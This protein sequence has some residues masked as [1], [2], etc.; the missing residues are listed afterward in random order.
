MGFARASMMRGAI[1]VTLM[2]SLAGGRGEAQ[3]PHWVVAWAASAQGP[4]PIGNPTAQPDLRFAFP[5]DTLGARDQTFRLIV[6]P[7]V[8]G[9]AARIRLSNAFGARPVDFDGIYVGLQTSGAATLAGH[10][11]PVTFRG[12]ARVTIPPGAS[13][14]SDPIALGFVGD[15]AD[16]LL[17]GRKLAVSFHVAGESGP[18]T[19]HAK[20]LTTSYVSAPG[21]GS[22]GAEA[23]EQAFPFSTTSWFFLDAVNMDAPADTRAIVALGDS[24]TDGT[25]S[26]INGDDRWPDVLSRRLH[27]TAG[28]RFSVVNAGIGGNQVIGPPDYA[29]HPVAGGPA[30]L[31]RLDRDVVSLSGVGVVIWLEGINDFGT[32]GASAAA[33]EA[34]VRDGVRRLRAALPGV[35]VYAATLTSAL[36]STNDAYGSTAV[37]AKRR[38]YNAFLLGA[39]ALFDGVFD[40]DGATVN[41]AT[42]ELKEEY[43][44]NSST[45]GPGDGLHPNRAGYAAMA[46]AIDLTVLAGR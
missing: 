10:P 12:V 42:G 13:A 15:P 6:R 9:R 37:N 19:W 43:R 35:K 23:G 29:Q 8:W 27:A 4:Y 16:P 22:H 21:S 31:D 14:V 34:G 38:A 40:F 33:V 25:A 5:S 30:A 36:H 28:T 1:G 39:G 7:D 46:N 32:A 45:G 26:T 44:P 41:P 3:A 17:A 20:G 18:M 2:A 11:A 24:I